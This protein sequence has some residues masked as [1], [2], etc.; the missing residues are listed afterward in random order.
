MARTT[1]WSPLRYRRDDRG[2]GGVAAW[3]IDSEYTQVDT[4]V[5]STMDAC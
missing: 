2:M 5:I 3:C 4:V 1:A